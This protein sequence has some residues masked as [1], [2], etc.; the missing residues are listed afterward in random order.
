[1]DVLRLSFYRSQNEIQRSWPLKPP[2]S[3]PQRHPPDPGRNVSLKDS[4]ACNLEC[5]VADVHHLDRDIDATTG[6]VGGI[7]GGGH[8]IY[9]GKCVGE[10]DRDRIIGIVIDT[11]PLQQHTTHT[12]KTII[13]H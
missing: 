8:R 12:G 7:N 9:I 2:Q 13:I 1:M 10:G 3:I 4:S 11:T 5:I 6:V